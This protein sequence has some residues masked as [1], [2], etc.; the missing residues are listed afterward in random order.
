VINYKVLRAALGSISLLFI[1]ACSNDSSS[2]ATSV[3]KVNICECA[4]ASNLRTNSF[5]NACN[6]LINKMM[7]EKGAKEYVLATRACRKNNK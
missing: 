1:T 2:S 5:V 3:K 4:I 7:K 6:N